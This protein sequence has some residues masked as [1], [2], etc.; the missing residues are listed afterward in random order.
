MDGSNFAAPA[1]SVGDIIEVPGVGDHKF[2]VFV[3]VDCRADVS[4]VLDE[5]AQ[6]HLAIAIFRVFKCVM[7]L[8]RV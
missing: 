8:E 3:V 1:F 7:Y 2:K 5:L 4:V 6:R